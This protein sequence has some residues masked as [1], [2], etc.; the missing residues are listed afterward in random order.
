MSLGVNNL[1]GRLATSD[2]LV[3]G[4]GAFCALGFGDR[5][6]KALWGRGDGVFKLLVSEPQSW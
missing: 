6:L 2:N 3:N 1:G 4:S 5:P